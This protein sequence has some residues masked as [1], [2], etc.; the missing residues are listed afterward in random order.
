MSAVPQAGEAPDE[1]VQILAHLTQHR[2]VRGCATLSAHD[3]R[4]LWSGG[5]AFTTSNNQDGPDAL[6][7][8]VRF[9]RELLDVT[10]RNITEV[11]DDVR[12]LLT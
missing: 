12:T 4:I 2:Q 6:E 11:R 9:V 1:A 10:H 8:I 5:A 7:R 3:G